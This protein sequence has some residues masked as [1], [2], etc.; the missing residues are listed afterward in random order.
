MPKT[1]TLA[2]LVVLLVGVVHALSS[3]RTTS[4]SREQEPVAVREQEP[5]AVRQQEPTSV[6][7]Q[8]QQPAACGKA[9]SDPAGA[10]DEEIFD[11]ARRRLLGRCT[12]SV[13]GPGK[14]CE[15]YVKSSRVCNANGGCCFPLS[16]TGC[17]TH[18]Y[19]EVQHPGSE[20]AWN[21]RRQDSRTSGAC[22]LRNLIEW[23]YC[24]DG[25]LRP[26]TPV[27][28]DPSRGY[29]P[30]PYGVGSDPSLACG[31]I[32]PSDGRRVADAGD[33]TPGRS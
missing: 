26:P 6:R 2:A 28:T 3:T 24:G 14:A 16:G 17:T 4:G 33:L 13:G 31:P 18:Y 11:C 9:L 23:G 27:T 15:H 30:D 21:C 25:E 12:V 32:P 10:S 7:E 5:V 20:V 1:F 22:L 8:E 29:W 19:D